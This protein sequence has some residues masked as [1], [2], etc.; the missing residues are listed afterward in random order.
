M[1]MI[2]NP[3]GRPGLSVHDALLQVEVFVLAIL[4]AMS[5]VR[6]LCLSR[7]RRMLATSACSSTE[8]RYAGELA[9]RA[10]FGARHAF[11]GFAFKETTCC[12]KYDRDPAQY[13]RYSPF[14]RVFCCYSNNA[15]AAADAIRNTLTR[16]NL[17]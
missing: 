2:R 3:L 15:P 13:W 4:F 8:N 16:S 7:S 9:H 11:Q 1:K 10:A 12:S 17:P 14:R 5:S 6:D